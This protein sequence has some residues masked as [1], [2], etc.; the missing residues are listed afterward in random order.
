M[1]VGSA[2]PYKIILIVL[3]IAIIE[4]LGQLCIKIIHNDPEKYHFYFITVI[5]Y[6]LVCFLL[7]TSYSHMGMGSINILWC[8]MSAVVVFAS[9]IMFF[10]EKHTNLDLLGILLVITGTVCIL[11]EPK[12]LS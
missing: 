12:A 2:F 9:G 1:D 10:C 6:S 4:S 7:Y 5:L 11:W 8:G 3:S